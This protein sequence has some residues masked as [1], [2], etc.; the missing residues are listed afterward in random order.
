MHCSIHFITKCKTLSHLSARHIGV[1]T[2]GRIAVGLTVATATSRGL[3][4]RVYRCLYHV[5]TTGPPVAAA[6]AAVGFFGHGQLRLFV[7][8]YIR[9]VFVVVVCG[10]AC[11]DKCLSQVRRPT[12]LT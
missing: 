5:I 8:Y 2:N 6:A 12:P 11:H 7:A 3:L 4:K 9:C 10:Y 1:T